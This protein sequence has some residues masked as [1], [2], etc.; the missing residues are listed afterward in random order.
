MKRTR[1]ILVLL[2]AVLLLTLT[3]CGEPEPEAGIGEQIYYHLL[4]LHSVS[5]Y[6]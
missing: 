4:K 3:A 1:W 6:K 2:S 5:L